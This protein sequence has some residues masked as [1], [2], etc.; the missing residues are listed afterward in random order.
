MRMRK[1]ITIDNVSDCYKVFAVYDCK[2][3]PVMTMT[4]SS[5]I[6]NKSIGN[7]LYT[8]LANS[9]NE[10]M[11]IGEVASVCGNFG[12][13]LVR[14]RYVDSVTRTIDPLQL[15][16]GLQKTLDRDESSLVSKGKVTN[17]NNHNHNDDDVVADKNIR[18]DVNSS[19]SNI[20]TSADTLRHQ[21]K[22]ETTKE[23][24]VDADFRD[25]LQRMLCKDLNKRMLLSEAAAH[26]FFT[27]EQ[28]VDLAASLRSF[29]SLLRSIQVAGSNRPSVTELYDRA[30]DAVHR[31]SHVQ[32]SFHGI[33]A[34]KKIQRKSKK[35]KLNDSMDFL[36]DEVLIK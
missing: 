22:S 30:L 13:G 16:N 32:N 2:Q 33:R 19:I 8:R 28:D 12:L 10:L 6:N 14:L 18:E 29:G 9:N 7:A 26:S 35:S 15:E 31:G 27:H 11:K 1:K 17:N 3:E 36:D 21:R 24:V 25:L 5:N 20:N 34:M 4:D 23:V